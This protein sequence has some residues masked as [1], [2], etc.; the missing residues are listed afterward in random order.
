M[1][2]EQIVE[3]ASAV[4]AQTGARP[5]DPAYVLAS[6]IPLELS[7]EAVRARLCVFTDH[8]GNEMVMR[9]DLTLPVAGMEADRLASGRNGPEAYTYAARAFRLPA[10]PND[11]MEFTQVG[12]ER[13]GRESSPD[14]DA[15]AFALVQAAVAACGID[16]WRMVMGDLSVFPAFVDALGLHG[17]TASLLKRAFRQEGGVAELLAG[18]PSAP[19]VELAH[20]LSASAP[21]AAA[22]AFLDALR[23]RS[24]PMIGTRS[25]AEIIEGLKAKA[26]AAD[27][28]GVPEDARKVLAALAGV[29]CSAPET[30]EALFGIARG[31]GLNGLDRVIERVARRVEAIIAAVPRV[32][33]TGKFRS[34]FGRRFTYYD[35]FV[36]ETYAGG[37][38]DR[39]PIATGGR[40]DGLIA[41]LSGGRARASGIGGV[42]RPDRVI[43]ARENVA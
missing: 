23:E 20:Q 26:A 32:A 15:G 16:D 21:E 19:E 27:A 41:G 36:F 11:P 39:Q 35:G 31:H 37:L 2:P 3:A 24:I 38:S 33:E 28:G 29:N 30:A 13:F 5:V 4:F 18:A 7:G 12:F 17:V 34:G 43:R 6:D 42:V 9:P 10:S 1:T 14:E 8:R 22:P 40:Y 25:V